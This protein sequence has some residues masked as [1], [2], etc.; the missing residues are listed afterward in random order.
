[1]SRAE[2]Q[3]KIQQLLDSVPD[4]VLA[5]L[6]EYLNG[7]NTN[8]PNDISMAMDLRK[9]LEEDKELLKRLAS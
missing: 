3:E 1:M 8:S 9:I 6:F 7:L 4:T 5:E 2:L